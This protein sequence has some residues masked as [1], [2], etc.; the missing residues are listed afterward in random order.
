MEFTSQPLPHMPAGW[1]SVGN[2]ANMAMFQTQQQS[3]DMK[4]GVGRAM[5]G[6]FPQKAHH[7]YENYLKDGRLLIRVYAEHGRTVRRIFESYAYHGCTLDDA[8]ERLVREGFRYTLLK[9]WFT[10]SKIA[11]ILKIGHTSGRFGSR[12]NGG[13]ART[14]ASLMLRP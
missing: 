14:A 12:A 8:F 5:A 10:R 3:V 6:L 9:A 13:P 2:L 7:G 4:E 11:D 1:M